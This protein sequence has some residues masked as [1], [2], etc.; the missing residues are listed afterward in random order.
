MDSALDS[1]AK[2]IADKVI[3]RAA[4]DRR[5]FR[6]VRLSLAGRVYIPTTEEEA[7]CAIESISPGDASI[8][9]ELK[10]E[11]SGRAVLYLDGLGRFE[12][13]IVRRIQDG[14]VMTFICSA[15]KRERL[16]EQLTLELNRE[17][18]DERD[19]RR[20]DRVEAASGSYAMFTRATGEQAK[21]EV[22]DLS[23]TGVSIR[24]DVKP[25]V[26]EHI[27]IGQRAGRV[28]RHHA[29]GIGVEFLG[30]ANNAGATPERLPQGL[31]IYHVPPRESAARSAAGFAPGFAKAS[32]Q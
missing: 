16:A 22:L 6:R 8:L 12:G 32:G 7:M 9:C 2:S 10:R 23:L 20:H 14:F 15:Q 1:T 30:V 5:R 26:G 13:P 31:G 25:A 27:L 4:K 24:T 18:V 21:C 17:L 11:P 29:N 3:A 28:A 19:L